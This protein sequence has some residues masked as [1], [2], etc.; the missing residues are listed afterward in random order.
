MPFLSL[1]QELFS[2]G[3]QFLM[4]LD[5]LDNFFGM[6]FHPMGMA[7]SIGFLASFPKVNS[8]GDIFIVEC[9]VE[10]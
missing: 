4:L 8:N 5:H 6:V 9:I 1:L 3:V 2:L 10:L 7:K